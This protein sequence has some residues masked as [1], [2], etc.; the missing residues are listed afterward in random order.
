MSTAKE[1]RKAQ[2]ALAKTGGER[3]ARH[4]F[5]CA[6]PEKAKC[7]DHA[8]GKESWNYL[9]KRLKQLGIGPSKKD[10]EQLIVRRT[11]ADCLQICDAGPIALVQPDGVWYH[12]CT[13]EVL[14]EI[15]QQHLIGGQP[16]EAYRL[17]PSR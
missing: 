1:L 12:S 10:E 17:H 14:E 4:I 8:Q 16:V 5:L 2:E 15:I 11:K 13:P 6:M 9:K 3:A 7:C